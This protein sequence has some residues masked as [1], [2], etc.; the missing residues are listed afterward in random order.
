M[1]RCLTDGKLRLG[2]GERAMYCIGTLAGEPPLRALR[3]HPLCRSLAP[4]CE[5]NRRS[6][7]R[8]LGVLGCAQLRE[9]VLILHM[10]LMEGSVRSQMLRSHRS[11]LCACRLELPYELRVACVQRAQLLAT[12][13]SEPS[14]CEL[15]ARTLVLPQLL[16]SESMLQLQLTQSGVTRGCARTQS[17]IDRWQRCQ[18]GRSSE[19]GMIARDQGARARVRAALARLRAAA[20]RAAARR[21]ALARASR[22]HRGS[23]NKDLV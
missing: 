16:N 11:D 19:S 9:A 4:D 10:R 23:E 14:G 1:R 7:S 5:G 8:S 6:L 13:A 12:A 21:A 3:A 22:E 18:R 20:R 17:A 15:M 2:L